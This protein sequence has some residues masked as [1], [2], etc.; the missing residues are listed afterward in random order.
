MTGV[1]ELCAVE[2]D[3]LA[4]DQLPITSTLSPT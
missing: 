3:A 2:L 1:Y 4:G